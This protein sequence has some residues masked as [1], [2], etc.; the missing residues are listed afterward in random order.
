MNP[1]LFVIRPATVHDVQP[2]LEFN[3][4]MA[5]ETEQRR[6]DLDR[7]RKGTLALLTQPQHGFY[8]VAET[9]V[10]TIR[11]AVG[12]LMITFEWSDWRNGVFWWVQSVY[13]RPEWRRRGVYRAMHEHIAARAKMDPQ[14]C[15]IRLYVEYRNHDAQTVY[16]RVGLSPS[17][18]T[19]YEEDF[20]LGPQRPNP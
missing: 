3:A 20:I 16:Q 11:T 12:Q 8:I 19:I 5:L 10:E 18:Y 14:V 4:A 1:D 6:L 13:V 17:V 2:I 15:G 9:S 7:L